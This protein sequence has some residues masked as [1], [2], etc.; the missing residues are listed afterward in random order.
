MNRLTYWLLATFVLSLAVWAPLHVSAL[1][2]AQAARKVDD[3]GKFFKQE[4]IDKAN[5][6]IA[7]LK[8][9]H[10]KD[11]IVATID[12]V[13]GL[14]S[15][16]PTEDANFA[17][18]KL[19]ASKFDREN[20][21]GVLIL[22]SK[23]PS[24]YR[25]RVGKVTVKKVFTAADE[26]KLEKVL[27]ESLKAGDLDG[28]LLNSVNYVCE[29]IAINDPRP[30]T[31][32]TNKAAAPPAGQAHN[33]QD[34]N[35]VLWI[36]VII[37]GLLVFWII[38]GIIRAITTP[39]MGPGYGGGPGGGGY[40]GGGY[41]GGGGGG[42]GFFSSLLGGMFGAA[43]GMWMYNSFFGGQSHSSFGA[44]PTN[45]GG[46]VGGGGDYSQ[47][48]GTDVGQGSV[49]GGGDWG[50]DSGGKDG[51][52]GGGDWGGGDKDAG[53]GGGGGDW[54]GGGDAGGGGGGGGGD[55]GGGGG[56]DWGGGGGGGGGGGDWGGGGGDF[57]GGG[58]GGGGDW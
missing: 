20:V 17:M 46:P 9:E 37:V 53:G 55:W 52:G 29:R 18:D 42:G 5:A 56:G 39:R 25:V 8:S 41:G 49:G 23:H 32:E 3:Q 35:W 21:D 33:P 34:V 1:G 16:S 43:A 58:G 44:G 11:L 19:A 31:T 10:H 7:K 57:G 28:A 48:Q 2:P 40:G 6:A 30:A 24:K 14:T 27:K 50:D 36:V 45:T 15:G 51:G 4:S 47:P 26:E 38:I 54:G 13:P 22:I 12:S